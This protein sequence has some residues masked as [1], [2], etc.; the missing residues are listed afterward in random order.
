[1][2][3]HW[4]YLLAG[5]VIVAMPG[6]GGSDDAASDG[7]GGGGYVQLPPDDSD[8]NAGGGPGGGGGGKAGRQGGGGGGRPGGGGGGRPTRPGGNA[9]T[10]VP[11]SN[12]V[13]QITPET[14]R[15]VFVGKHTDA[16]KDDR[17]GGF[18]A[19]TGMAKVADGVVTAIEVEIDVKSVFTFNEG[20]TNHLKAPDFFE[21][22]EFPNAKFTSSSIADGTVTGTLEMHGVSKEITFPATVTVSDDGMVL[23]SEFRINRFD[24]EMNGAKDS[25]VDEV[26]MAISVG[27]PTN[28]DEITGAAGGGGGR[29]GRGGG[30]GGRGGGRGG[31][32]PMEMFEQQDANKDGKLSGDEISEQMERFIDRVDTNGDGEVSKEEME[33]MAQRFQQRGGGGR[34]GRGGGG[35]RGGGGGRPAGDGDSGR[36]QR[37]GGE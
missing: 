26:A 5:C 37:P 9:A 19:F 8:P 24:F 31:W 1:M 10:P 36:S 17:T 23:N 35:R 20:L 12:G 16:A 25:V 3:I 32:D 13:V 29:G 22:N 7:T 15:I 11:V 18:E 2:R 21:V 4:T 27:K 33:A 30:G 14:S 34:G 6:C 28:K